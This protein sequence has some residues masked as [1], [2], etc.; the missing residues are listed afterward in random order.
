MATDEESVGRDQP[1]GER[2]R[3][4]PP[5][6][7]QPNE[8][9]DAATQGQRAALVTSWRAPAA[10]GSYAQL[11]M[12]AASRDPQSFG[13]IT[14]TTQM[15][16]PHAAHIRQ[17]RQTSVPPAR[18]VGEA[19]VCHAYHACAGGG[20][21]PRR[22]QRR[23]RRSTRTAASGRSDQAADQDRHARR[24]WVER[25]RNASQ[26]RVRGHPHRRLLEAPAA[27][28]HRHARP[29]RTPNRSM[30]YA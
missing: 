27:C 23:A 25:M 24:G 26:Q 17:V 4:A 16:R 9:P 2:P 12:Q 8:R 3:G 29:C 1:L 11:E 30:G 21:R 5:C 6:C 7:R 22:A 14:V 28:T 20:E 19:A 18:P 15:T 10:Q 13:V